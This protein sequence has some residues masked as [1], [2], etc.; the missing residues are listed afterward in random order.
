MPTQFEDCETEDEVRALIAVHEQAKQPF[1]IDYSKSKP[2]QDAAIYT[3][4]MSAGYIA[5]VATLEQQQA[6]A[7]ASG[8]Q[9]DDPF[10]QMNPNFL[11]GADDLKFIKR[12]SK[13]CFYPW[14]LYSAGQGA[15]TANMA[16]KTDWLT[17][18]PRE[19]GVVLLGDSGGFQLQQQT[20]PFD[21]ATTPERMLKWLERVADHSMTLD[22]PIG[23]IDKGLWFRMSKN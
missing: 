6:N 20:I 7:K 4:A 1:G 13:L 8:N 15:Q 18:T 19:Q 14:H 2:F 11:F 5:S 22:F 21:P 3:P 17:Q 16:T 12:S 23:G 10:Y 9:A